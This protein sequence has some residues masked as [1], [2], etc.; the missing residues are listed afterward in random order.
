MNPVN[1]I[2]RSMHVI[3]DHCTVKHQTSGKRWLYSSTS[4][5]MQL[6]DGTQLNAILSV[7]YQRLL[8]RSTASDNCSYERP[9]HSSLVR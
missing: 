2:I 3:S 1:H 4:A 8:S 9:R 6:V 7:I 5:R